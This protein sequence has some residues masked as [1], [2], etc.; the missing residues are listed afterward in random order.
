MQSQLPADVAAIQAISAVPT[1]LEAVAAITGLGFVCI[2]RV[3]D[4]TWTTCAVRDRLGFGL[5]PGDQLDITTTLCEQVRD[6]RS[7]IVIDDVHT[8][9]TYREHHTPRI[10]GFRS[11]IS[12]PI[13]RPDGEYFGTLCGLDPQ[14]A[15]LS[16]TQ[17]LA[18]LTLFAQLIALQLTSESALAAAEQ[19]LLSERETAE[20]REQFIAVLGHDVRNP[21]G[22]IANGADL[23]LLLPEIGARATAVAQRIQRSAQRITRMIDDVLDFTRGRMGGGIPLTLRPEAALDT[24]LEQVVAELRAQHPQRTIVT[25]IMPVDGLLC[26]GGRIGQLLSNLLNNALVHGDP[27]HS[28]TVLAHYRARRFTLAV[29]NGGPAIPP[30]TLAQLFKPFW[31]ATGGQASA[32]LGLGLFIVA[33]IARSHGASIDVSSVPDRTT[34][35]FTMNDAGAAAA[36]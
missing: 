2:A 35:V 34:F 29:S 31:R 10:Y 8:D 4:N 27:E 32:G 22:A 24:L 3:T 21:L 33:E 17:T 18:S 26:D 13:V 7:T 28:V 9:T 6:T 12:V 23:L 25:D 1:I 14:P 5:A 20:L 15:S 30:D 36:P 16:N 11:Y 19:A